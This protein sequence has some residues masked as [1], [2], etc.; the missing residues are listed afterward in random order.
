M[1]CPVIKSDCKDNCM[2]KHRDGD[3]R[4]D[5]V[6]AAMGISKISNGEL[7]VGLYILDFNGGVFP[8]RIVKDE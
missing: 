3:N 2:F 8:I 6:E 1:F 5:L 7:S 4:C